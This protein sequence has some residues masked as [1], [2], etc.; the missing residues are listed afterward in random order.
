MLTGKTFLAAFFAVVDLLA[1]LPYYIEVALHQD[2]VCGIEID[3][4]KALYGP[5][6]EGSAAQK[7]PPA[8]DPLPLLH[9]S[10]LSASP[11]I[12]GVQIP[13]SDALVCERCEAFTPRL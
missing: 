8:V 1:I 4:T 2:T 10:N 11:G 9:P 7:L 5:P 3:S 12:Q 6:D 13:E